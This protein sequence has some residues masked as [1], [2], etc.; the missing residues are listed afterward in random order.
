MAD[1]ERTTTLGVGADTAFAFFA[2]PERIPEYVPTMAHVETIAVDGDES[3]EMDPRERQEAD[4]ARFFVDRAARRVEWGL[5][6]TVYAGSVVVGPGTASTC[7][8]TISLHTRDD[9]DSAG[10]ERML[11]EALRNIRRTVSGR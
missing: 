1:F 8:V 11:D 9:V 10:V 3:A 5:P 7:Q 6:G 4:E 2:D